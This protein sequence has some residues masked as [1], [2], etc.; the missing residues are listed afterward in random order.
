MYVHKTDFSIALTTLQSS[1]MIVHIFTLEQK[2]NDTE[3]K[4]KKR[5]GLEP[6][7]QGQSDSVLFFRLLIVGS[8]MI[9]F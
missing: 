3:N 8:H 2:K 5:A 6:R 9:I 4:N 7:S 1:S